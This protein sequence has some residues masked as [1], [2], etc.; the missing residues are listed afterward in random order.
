[1]F[2]VTGA[3]LHALKKFQN[4]GKPPRYGIDNWDRVSAVCLGIL[5]YQSAN[6]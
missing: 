4:D 5:D 1:M 6:A 2:G 3:G